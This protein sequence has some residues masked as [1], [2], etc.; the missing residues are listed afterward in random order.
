MVNLY[1]NHPKV[2]DLYFTTEHRHQLKLAY[3]S[4]KLIQYR[5]GAEFTQEEQDLALPMLANFEQEYHIRRL[6]Q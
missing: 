4:F 3:V 1:V 5:I 6:M 2:L